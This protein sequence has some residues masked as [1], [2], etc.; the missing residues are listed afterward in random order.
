MP[1]LLLALGLAALAA[2]APKAKAPQPPEPPPEEDCSGAYDKAYAISW[3]ITRERWDEDCAAGRSPKEILKDRQ[4]D[5][6]HECRHYFSKNKKDEKTPDWK[7]QV[8]CAQGTAGERRLAEMTGV[9][10]RAPPV[11][12]S[13][14]LLK[15]YKIAREH[16]IV[17]KTP[18][19]LLPKGK[20]HR[21]L[22]FE[23]FKVWIMDGEAEVCV[24][25]TRK[26]DPATREGPFAC[27][28]GSSAARYILDEGCTGKRETMKFKGVASD[29]PETCDQADMDR[30]AEGLLKA[31]AKKGGSAE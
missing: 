6:V 25:D 23:P 5:F 22:P 26:L 11:P 16:A 13:P 24:L 14:P 7:I 15:L 4:G 9:P 30:L 19:D 8:E 27:R 31:L 12:K 21:Y 1:A 10:F 20:T 18:M 29:P 3:K 17:S 2:A 28:D